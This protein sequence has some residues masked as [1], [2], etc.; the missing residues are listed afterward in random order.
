MKTKKMNRREFMLLAGSAAVA[1]PLAAALG[2]C[3]GGGSSSPAPAAAGDFVVTSTSNNAHTHDITVRAAD[4]LAGVQVTY[5]STSTGAPSH[6]HTVT[7]TPAQ[8][9]DINSGKSD[10]IGSSIDLGHGHDFVIKKP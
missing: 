5:N 6:I 2:G 8:I 10:S 3:G 9:N 4:L 1:L 7:I